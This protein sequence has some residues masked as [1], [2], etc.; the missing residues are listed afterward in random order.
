MR[1]FLVVLASC[2]SSAPPPK[3]GGD[4][5]PPPR[6]GA[7]T[8]S[9]SACTYDGPWGA[10]QP[11][12]L[13]LGPGGPVFVTA[14]QTEQAHLELAGTAAR[15]EIEVDGFQF[16][17][18][19]DHPVVHPARAFV[20]AGYLVPGSHSTLRPVG[21]RP[22]QLTV[23]ITPPAFVK[24]L[25]P[26]RDTRPCR[27]LG[28]DHTALEPASALDRALEAKAYTLPVSTPI[29]LAAT[30][31]ASP[32]AELRFAAEPSV[33][34]VE[35]RGDLARIFVDEFHD[36]AAG[37]AVVGWVA[38]SLLAEAAGS[39]SEG[40][41]AVGSAPSPNS[42]LS[43]ARR[44]VSCTH[45][46]PLTVEAGAVREQAG[47]VTPGTK[48]GVLDG[49]GDLVPITLDRIA[50]ELAPGVRVMVKRSAIAGCA[51]VPR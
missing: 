10:E 24:P 42:G 19:V 20:M 22:H 9:N 23:E 39:G 16:V 38:R 13:R 14:F 5:I 49:D 17:G 1:R 36:R 45:E 34:I 51:D 3:S 32:V 30:H 6:P 46:V 28:L 4:L 11:R 43:R 47:I 44:H 26:T 48:F 37:V 27:D 12:E 33:R 50:I 8:P 29:P 41:W 21:T 31:G 7:V 15:L 35:Q 25:A 18:H 2:C 40:G